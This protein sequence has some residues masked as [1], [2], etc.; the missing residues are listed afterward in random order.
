MNKKLQAYLVLLILPFS[1]YAQTDI[2]GKNLNAAVESNK[3]Y[4]DS[5]AQQLFNFAKLSSYYLNSLTPDKINRASLSYKFDKGHYVPTQGATSLNAGKLL[6][7][8][9]VKL[10]TIKLYGSFSY[11]KTFEDSTRFAHQTRNNVTTPYYYGSPAYVH[12]ERS[13]Y[14]FNAMANKNFLN[15]KLSVA[16]GTDYKV[17]DHYATNDPRGAI[18]EYQ[19]NLML[20]LGYR[21]SDAVKIG[22]AYRHGYGQEKVNVAYK[23]Q[24]YYESSSFPLYYNHLINGYGEGKPVLTN[25]RYTDNQKRNGIDFYVDINSKSIGDFYFSASYLTEDQRYFYN[26]DAG[27]IEYATYNL[28]TVNLNLLWNKKVER[29][30]LGASINY[31]Q[32]DGKDYNIDFKANNYKYFSKNLAAKVF[33]T[34]KSENKL[35]NHYLSIKQTDEE[36]VDGIKANDIYFNNIFLKAGSGIRINKK[37]NNYF[38][39]G[40]AANYNL[41]ANDS[42]TVA[43][44]NEGYFTRYVI[45]YDYLYNTSSYVG[46][47]INAEYS[48]PIFKT[49]QAALQINAGYIQKLEQKTINRT[50]IT[51]PGKDRFTSN[52]SLN[53]YF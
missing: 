24:R 1:V 16:A 10:G 19:F 20:S 49:M 52:F 4:A 34:T 22:L 43:Q 33:L 25:R 6:T 14:D 53:L 3:F 8:G 15:E 48:L 30:S 35:F 31:K 40:L 46:G 36:R 28:S 45:Y 2:E 42:F 39:I 11:T 37:N 50:I 47:E 23:N 5:T 12:Y 17:G 21:L 7:E 29:G 44:T 9:T 27:F 26:N 38:G 32:H 41:P 51:A 18:G 13:I